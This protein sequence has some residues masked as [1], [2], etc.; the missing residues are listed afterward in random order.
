MVPMDQPSNAMFILNKFLMT[1]ARD[2]GLVESY[3]KETELE[4]VYE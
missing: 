2:R 4:I 1:N 3:A